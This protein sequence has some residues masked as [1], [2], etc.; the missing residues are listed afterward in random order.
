MV[1]YRSTGIP[2]ENL[3]KGKTKKSQMKNT[4]PFVSTFNLRNPD[5]FPDIKDVPKG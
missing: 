3:R 5:F 4:L 2:I 1:G